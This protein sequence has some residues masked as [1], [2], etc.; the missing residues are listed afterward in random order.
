MQNKNTHQ[1]WGYT[2]GLKLYTTKDLS[3]DI[4]NILDIY[5]FLVKQCFKYPKIRHSKLHKIICLSE[6]GYWVVSSSLQC[7][8]AILATR[9]RGHVEVPRSTWRYYNSFDI[10]FDISISWPWDTSLNVTGD[11]LNSKDYYYHFC[12]LAFI[13]V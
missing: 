9:S 11:K 8:Q 12:F 5:F 3:G 2:K 6:S 4:L 1:H 7:C 10:P 13:S